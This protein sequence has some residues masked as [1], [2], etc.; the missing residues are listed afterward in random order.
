MRPPEQGSLEEKQCH[1]S[2]PESY[3]GDIR[4]LPRFFHLH[5]AQLLH[6]NV[7]EDACVTAHIRGSR[8][9]RVHAERR[10]PTASALLLGFG[11]EPG[12]IGVQSTPVGNCNGHGGP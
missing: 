8:I 2:V 3:Q 5:M 6:G 4:G 12:Q 9:D 7:P 10:N 11:G 1:Q